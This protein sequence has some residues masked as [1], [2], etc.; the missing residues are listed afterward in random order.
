MKVTPFTAT[1]IMSTMFKAVLPAFF[2]KHARTIRDMI[3]VKKLGA[4]N[5]LNKPRPRVVSHRQQKKNAP[6]PL[7][8]D[9]EPVQAR[10]T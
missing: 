7:W 9:Q 1:S 2:P 6:N 3:T 4:I 8:L 10:N 5:A